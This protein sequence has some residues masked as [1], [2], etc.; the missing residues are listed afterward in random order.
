MYKVQNKNGNMTGYLN[1]RSG[2]DLSAPIVGRLEV[3]GIVNASPY[4]DSWY[5][6][7]GG[8]VSADYLREVKTENASKDVDPLNPSE[9]VLK[10]TRAEVQTMIDYLKGL[11]NNGSK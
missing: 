2:P 4:N 11:L 9:I 8:Y 10:Y 1:V 5:K 7:T 6:V 3:N